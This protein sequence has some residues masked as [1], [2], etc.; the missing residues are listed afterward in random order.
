MG[1]A[2]S[3]PRQP[4]RVATD[5]VVLLNFMDDTKIYRSIILDLM[6]RFDDVLDPEK[7]H[8][9]LETLLDHGNW[10]KL[11]ARLRLNVRPLS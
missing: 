6:L 9:S 5:T 8:S 2:N 7:L 3:K 11:G 10:R 4:E 1:F